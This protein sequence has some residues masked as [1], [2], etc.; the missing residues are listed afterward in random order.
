MGLDDVGLAH[1]PDP[2]HEA[3]EAIA[4]GDDRV[5]AEEKSLRPLLRPR[6]L[7]KHN[8]HL[9]RHN[10]TFNLA[11]AVSLSRGRAQNQTR[12]GP[13]YFR[14]LRNSATSEIISQKAWGLQNTGTRLE[15]NAL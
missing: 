13:F 7:R 14:N 10:F 11:E 3:V 9:K 1:V 5:S 2:E 12:H 6:Q 15:G 4:L 8:T